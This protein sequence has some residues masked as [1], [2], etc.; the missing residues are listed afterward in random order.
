MF[1]KL[2]RI[3]FSGILE[4][5]LLIAKYLFTRKAVRSA[6]STMWENEKLGTCEFSL[7]ESA[8]FHD[9]LAKRYWKATRK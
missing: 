2:V 8:G 5:A 4:A 9:R 6:I 7:R 1:V 3:S